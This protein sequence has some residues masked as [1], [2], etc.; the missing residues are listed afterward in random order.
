MFGFF[1]NSNKTRRAK[2]HLRGYEYA[3][4]E[5]LSGRKTPYIL[6]AEMCRVFESDHPFDDGMD[7]AIRDAINKGL[8]KDDRV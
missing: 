1:K 2:S 7:D 3:A 4:G 5:L 8:C 6:E